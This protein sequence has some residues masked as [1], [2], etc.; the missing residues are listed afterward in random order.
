MPKA[1]DINPEG[2]NDFD[3]ETLKSILEVDNSL[4]ESEI[5]GIK[6]FYGKFDKTL[7][8][9]LSKELETLENNLK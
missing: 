4:W 8:A 3:R 7:P 1:E 9:E 5:D 6:E 2:L